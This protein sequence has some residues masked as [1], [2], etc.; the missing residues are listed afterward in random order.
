[1]PETELSDSELIKAFG[2]GAHAAFE[3]L[4]HR[5]RRQL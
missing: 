4:Y 3:T 1:M 2:E 5:Y